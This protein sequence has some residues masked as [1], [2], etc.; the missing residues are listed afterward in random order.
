MGGLSGKHRFPVLSAAR[1]QGYYRVF[2]YKKRLTGSKIQEQLLNEITALDYD[3]II[4]VDMLRGSYRTKKFEA[5]EDH[6]A[7]IGSL[8][9][10][11]MREAADYCVDEAA[12]MEYLE[13]L[14]IG[15]M[16]NTWVRQES[17]KLYGGNV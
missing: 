6:R 17:S 16:R 2:L 9:S 3:S 7:R 15:Y 8:Y 4:E 10:V 1:N 12:R 14:D 5:G 13:K 11:F